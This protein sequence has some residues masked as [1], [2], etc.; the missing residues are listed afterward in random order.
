MS[1]AFHI[2][3]VYQKQ[4]IFIIRLEA[5]VG[6]SQMLDSLYGTIW[7]GSRVRL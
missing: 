7:R 5:Y 4:Y 3:I 2:F 1:Q 6:F